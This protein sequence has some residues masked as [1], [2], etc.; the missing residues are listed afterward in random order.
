MTT[1]I[2]VNRRV[3]AKNSA[4]GSDDP[5]ISIRHNKSGQPYYCRELEIQGPSRL[6]YD[7]RKPI[8][9]CGARLVIATEA[10]VKVLR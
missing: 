8:L 3:I 5:P 9:S 2:S 7:S 6:M 4:T 10:N 1:Y